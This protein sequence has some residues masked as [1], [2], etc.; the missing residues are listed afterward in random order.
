MTTLLARRSQ[1][2]QNHLVAKV[3]A[4][5][6]QTLRLLQGMRANF[7]AHGADGVTASRKALGAVYG[8]VQQH[9]AMLAFV[10]ALFVMGVVFL[11]MLLFLPL[12]QYSKLVCSAKALTE[13][14]WR[15]SRR[16]SHRIGKARSSTK[17]TR[18]STISFCTDR[19]D[20]FKAKFPLIFRAQP[21]EIANPRL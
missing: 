16:I 10:E 5:N 14:E 17:R 21:G 2:H 8:M 18:K 15:S 7:V 13:T 4:G 20:G 1:L 19:R 3:T 11:L 12:L 9:A 6:P